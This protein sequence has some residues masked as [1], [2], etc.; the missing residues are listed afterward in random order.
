MTFLTLM[1]TFKI[2]I[3]IFQVQKWIIYLKGKSNINIKLQ[4]WC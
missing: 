1:Y 3:N 4:V 2:K